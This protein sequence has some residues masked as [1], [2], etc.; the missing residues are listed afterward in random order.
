MVFLPKMGLLIELCWAVEVTPTQI[1]VP[2][3]APAGSGFP[4]RCDENTVN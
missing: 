4:L 1:L 3:W 2:M